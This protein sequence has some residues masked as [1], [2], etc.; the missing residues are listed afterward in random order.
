MLQN[1]CSRANS[2]VNVWSLGR[3]SEHATI[4]EL[5][6]VP[7]HVLYFGIISQNCGVLKYLLYTSGLITLKEL[8]NDF[9][10]TILTVHGKSIVINLCLLTLHLGSIIDKVVNRD[11]SCLRIYQAI[12]ERFVVYKHFLLVWTKWDNKKI[13]YWLQPPDRWMALTH[14]HPQTKRILLCLARLPRR[15]VYRSLFSILSMAKICHLW[16]GR[17]PH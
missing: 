3:V 5:L 15:T 7:E 11:R 10:S 9:I 17:N 12:L 8:S 1:Y 16:G 2:Q 14:R 4:F 13:S 6:K